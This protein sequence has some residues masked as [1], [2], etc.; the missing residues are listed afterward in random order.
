[1]PTKYDSVFKKEAIQ[2]ALSSSKPMTV[3]AK[4]LGMKEKTLQNWVA[5]E[6]QARNKPKAETKKVQ[7]HSEKISEKELLKENYLLRK[8]ISRLEEAQ[9]ILKKAEAF[10]AK[11]EKR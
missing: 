5:I 11:K 2:L 1:M 8:R 9:E 6:K 7:N 10:F 3:L 4:Q